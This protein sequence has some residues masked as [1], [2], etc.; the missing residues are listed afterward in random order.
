MARS[1]VTLTTDFGA[2]SVYVAQLKGSLLRRSRDVLLVDITHDIGPQDVRAAALVLADASE[3]FPRDALHVAVVDPGVGTSRALVAAQFDGR[4]VLG[5]D[6]GIFDGLLAKGKPDWAFRLEAAEY[7]NARVAA[8]FHG[9]DI[10]A[11]VAAQLLEGLAPMKLGPPHDLAKRLE[12]PEA[13]SADASVMGEVIFVDR[14]GNLVT[15][16][17]AALLQDARARSRG[18]RG[19]VRCGARAGIEWVETYGD[20]PSGSIV[21]L[22]GSSNRLE[23]AMVNGNAAEALG[24]GAGTEVEWTP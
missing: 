10:L 24:V 13:R 23:V 18:G 7:W 19:K 22:L 6:N 9:R 17:E 21:A 5:P 4:R 15:N 3:W 11:P 2:G 14:F 16:L 8:T 12:W 20:C 1:I